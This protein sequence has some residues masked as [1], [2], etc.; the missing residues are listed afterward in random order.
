MS[1]KTLSFFAVILVFLL[2]F[3]P[4]KAVEITVDGESYVYPLGS[5]IE[6]SYIHSVERSQVVEV[7]V[8]NDSGFYAVEMKWKDF[9]AGL[10]EDIQNLTDGFYVKK[11][12]DYLGKEFRYWFIPI[13][14]ANI[15][16]DGSPV[17]V[18]SDGGRQVVV[19]FRIKRVPLIMKLIGRW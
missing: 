5:A 3:L 7:L 17:I 1:R 15:T 12:R 9:G 4:V 16:V 8:A 13:N 11:T 2:P 14:H 18:D 19:D 10:P 6:I